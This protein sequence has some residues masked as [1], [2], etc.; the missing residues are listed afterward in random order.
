MHVLDLEKILS[1]KNIPSW[2]HKAAFELKVGVYL[3]AGEYFE[4]LDDEEIL[5]LYN[6]A[7]N[8]DTKDFVEFQIQSD[9]SSNN[10]KHLCLLCFILA[11]GEGEI[12]LSPELLSDMLQSLFLLISIEKMHRNNQ[13]DVMRENYSVLDGSRPV[14]KEKGKK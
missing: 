7:K 8:V 12:G 5:H 14:V 4:K 6:C 9:Q 2:I 13:V 11:Q 1:T 3:P 10:L